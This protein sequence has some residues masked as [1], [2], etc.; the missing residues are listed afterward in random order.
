MATAAIR[1]SQRL[2]ATRR[3]VAAGQAVAERFG[4]DPPA[5]P[6]KHRDPA[7]LPTLQL[8][9]MADFLES[10]AGASEPKAKAK[11]TTT[12]AAPEAKP[13]AKA[14]ADA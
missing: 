4:I 11:A 1:A 2:D 3:V 12:T 10:L 13:K 8:E 6:D 7:Y 14:K 5:I 9:A